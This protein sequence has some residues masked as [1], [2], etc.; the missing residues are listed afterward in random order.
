VSSFD[1]VEGIFGEYVDR[2]RR[3]DFGA[4]S[5]ERERPVGDDGMVVPDEPCCEDVAA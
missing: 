1:E 2:L 3:G 4:P 5:G